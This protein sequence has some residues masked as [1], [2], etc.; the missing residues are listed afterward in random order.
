VRAEDGEGDKHK[1]EKR[2]VVVINEDGKERVIEGD[3]MSAKRGF[4]GV[5]LTD[6]SPEL[7]K[8]FGAPDD[9]GVMVAHI[10]DGSPADKA[11][12]RIGDIVTSVDGDMVDSSFELSA[13]I[14]KLTDGQQA[15]FEI[16]RDGR[17]QKLTAVIVERE[18][19][20]IDMGPLFFKSKEGDNMVFRIEKDK[21]LHGKAD[22][23]KLTWTEDGD[24]EGHKVFLRRMGSPREAELEK[25]LQQLEKRIAELE[26]A[27]AKKN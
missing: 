22:G 17:S 1:I 21:M 13:R 23:K 3:A 19:P 20:A 24:G 6:L 2:R 4:L 9:A 27:L 16:Y 26:K 10:E 25:Q 5:G 15:G 11:G 7:R 14:R 12:L 8:H 18:R